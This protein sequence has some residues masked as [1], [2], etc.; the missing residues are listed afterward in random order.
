MGANMA[1]RLHDTGHAVVA[2]YEHDRAKT[3]DLAKEIRSQPAAT[4]AAVTAAVPADVSG[5]CAEQSSAP[6]SAARSSSQ[7]REW[8]ARVSSS[9]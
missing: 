5:K 6:L 1:R 2:V 7:R 3:A 8:R 4:L 9:A